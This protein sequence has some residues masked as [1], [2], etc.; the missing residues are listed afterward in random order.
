MHG[1][2]EQVSEGESIVRSNFLLHLGFPLPTDDA[3]D[4]PQTQPLA[5]AFLLAT[6][7]GGRGG[8]TC[9]PRDDVQ[10]GHCVEDKNHGGTGNGQEVEQ[11]EEYVSHFLSEK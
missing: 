10:I 2:P 7:R 8:V 4:A 6:S 3:S 9:P 5:Q 1:V 11:S